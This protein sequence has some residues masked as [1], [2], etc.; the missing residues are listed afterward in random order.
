[1]WGFCTFR[2]G[3]LAR[4]DKRR[5]AGP[6]QGRRGTRHTVQPY[7]VQPLH[8]AAAIQC[9]PLY[10]AARYA[11]AIQVRPAIQCGARYTVRG[12]LYSAARYTVR[13]AIQCGPLYSAAPYTVRPAIQRGPISTAARYTVPPA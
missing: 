1:G 2:G 10:S 9:G 6:V 5:S 12:P 13:P 11:P 4:G 8:S 7:T 3:W